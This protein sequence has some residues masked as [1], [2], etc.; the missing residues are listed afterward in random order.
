MRHI[1]RLVTPAYTPDA[2][3]ALAEGLEAEARDG[4]ANG[5]IFDNTA[6]LAATGDAL[7]TVERLRLAPMRT[8]VA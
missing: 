8:C 5:C 2:L 6:A 4:V 3:D 7:P 1:R